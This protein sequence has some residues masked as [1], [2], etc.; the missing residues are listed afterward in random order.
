MERAVQMFAAVNF[1]VIGMSHILQPRAWVELFLL[2]R[3]KGRTG[4]FVNA[5]L[6]L[7]PGSIIVSFHNVWSGPATVLTILGWSQVL[8]ALLIFVRPEIGLKSLARISKEKSYE[9]VVAGV[10]LVAIGFYLI[11]LILADQ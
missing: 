8:K 7:V 3:E 2:L 4:A 11:W 5:F 10:L 1:L 9:F 6:S